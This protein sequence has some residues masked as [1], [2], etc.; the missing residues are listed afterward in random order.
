MHTVSQVPTAWSQCKDAVMQVAH[1]STTTCQACETKISSGQLRL[2]VM[3]LHVDGFMLVEW[4]HLSCQPWLVTAF[5]TI[6]FIDRGCLNGDQA[7]SIRQWL[8][9][10]QCQLTESSASDILALEAWNAVVPM[11][12]SL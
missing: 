6:S 4:I 2:G 10:C 5:D 11:T 3:Y 7:Q 9:S 8:T 1:T 12:S